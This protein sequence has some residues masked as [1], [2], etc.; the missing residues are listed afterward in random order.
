MDFLQLNQITAELLINTAEKFEGGERRIFMAEVVN[1]LGPGGQREAERELG[2]NRWTIRKGLK[3]LETGIIIDNRSATGRKKAEEHLPDLMKDIK[4]IVEPQSQTDPTFR[5]TQLYIPLTAG[6]VRKLLIEEKGYSD[7]ELPTERTISNKLNELNYRPQKVTKSKPIKKI[8]ETDAIFDQLHKINP[9]A[10]E[11]EG[12]IRMSMDAKA[13]IKIGPYSRCGYNRGGLKG[14]D[15]D[16]NPD[17]ILKL[18]GIHLPAYDK[19]YLFFSKSKVT[20][21]FMID[22]LESIWLEIE[23]KY[24]PHTLVINSDNGPECNSH[25]TQFIKRIVEFA[26]SKGITIKLAY[27]P[28]YHSKYNP[29]ERV[30]GILENHWN[31]EILDSVCKRR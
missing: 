15:H 31:G 30:W 26:I 18:F 28:P 21:D 13:D 17:D 4:D 20:P 25:R 23:Q 19:Q 8:P 14:A 1:A 22:T 2:W 24:N 7:K 6:G 29:V 11:A 5:T 16:F 27:Y 9:E 10:D 3:E 12:V